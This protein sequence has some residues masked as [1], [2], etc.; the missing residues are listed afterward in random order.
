M[1]YQFFDDSHMLTLHF[2]PFEGRFTNKLPV[3]IDIL[4]LIWLLKAYR[5]D[6]IICCISL[7][8]FVL[9]TMECSQVLHPS[10]SFDW[11]T[12]IFKMNMP[13]LNLNRCKSECFGPTAWK[14]SLWLL[15][16]PGDW[17]VIA[18]LNEDKI[19]DYT[20]TELKGKLELEDG[21]CRAQNLPPRSS[22]ASQ[23]S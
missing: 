10:F 11:E 17:E 2:N 5:N 8:C 9:G 21:N 7:S 12:I 3:K 18:D 13:H 4:P 20:W 14:L 6:S 1:L 15:R 19:S 23:Y 22:D 16:I